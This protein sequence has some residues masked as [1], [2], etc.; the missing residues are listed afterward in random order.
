MEG[1]LLYKTSK[2]PCKTLI[3]PFLKAINNRL[4]RKWNNNHSRLGTSY[5]HISFFFT[6][7]QRYWAHHL[8]YSARRHQ[9]QIKVEVVMNIKRHGH[10]MLA[11]WLFDG[12]N[13]IGKTDACYR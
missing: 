8:V 5:T 7:V 12:F 1:P 3:L 11:H 2:H 13:E 9:I 10:Q 6:C 4:P